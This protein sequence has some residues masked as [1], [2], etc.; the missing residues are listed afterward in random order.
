MNCCADWS[1]TLVLAVTA[2]PSG[3]DISLSRLHSPATSVMCWAC[4]LSITSVP[5]I[6]IS[7]GRDHCEPQTIIGATNWS[8]R[9]AALVGPPPKFQDGGACQRAARSQ[10]TAAVPARRYSGC[11]PQVRGCTRVGADCVG[12]VLLYPIR[13]AGRCHRPHPRKCDGFAVAP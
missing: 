10:R 6:G 3:C 11:K 4:S 9:P 7:L 5:L 2:Y 8:H 12:P 13:V 1:S